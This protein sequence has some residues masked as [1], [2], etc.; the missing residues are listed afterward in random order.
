MTQRLSHYQCITCNLVRKKST[1]KSKSGPQQGTYRNSMLMAN[2]V[3]KK[4]D[5]SQDPNSQDNS[6]A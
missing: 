6:Q 1:M 5:P 4:P 3:K 2:G